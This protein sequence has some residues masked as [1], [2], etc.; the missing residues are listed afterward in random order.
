MRSAQIAIGSVIAMGGLAAW[1]AACGG[2]DN[3]MAPSANDASLPDSGSPDS[4]MAEPSSDAGAPGDAKSPTGGDA[5]S[6]APPSD[7][8]KAALCLTVSPES[9]QFVPSVPAF[10]GKGVLLVAIQAMAMPDGGQPVVAPVIM[11]DPDGGLDGGLVDLSQP[12]PTIRVDGIPATTVYPQVVFID[13]PGAGIKNPVPGWWLGNYDLSHGLQGA[14]LKPVTLQ[15]GQ[16]AMVTVDLRALRALSLQVTAAVPPAGNG[17]GPMNVIVT[18]SNDVAHDS[19]AQAWGFGST[20]CI[21]CVADGGGKA[22]AF[23]VGQGP[24]YTVPVLDDFG[25]GGSFPPGAM[26][27][28]DVDAGLTVPEAN[29]FTAGNAYVVSQS[30]QLNYVGKAPDGGIDEASCP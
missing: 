17:Q 4:T 12:I 28:L 9:V 10:D 24:Y 15:A 16:S 30:V 26:T 22:I 21:N 25:L 27:S 29:K 2:D 20:S 23:F 7:P 8:T 1:L 11:P 13:D 6:C 3:G 5:G 18:D 14:G 19:G